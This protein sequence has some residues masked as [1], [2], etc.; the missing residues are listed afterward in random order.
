MNNNSIEETRHLDDLKHVLKIMRTTI[1]LLFFSIMFI[2]ASNS[3]SQGLI[4]RLEAASIKEV[5]KK[6]RRTVISSSCS[7]TQVKS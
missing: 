3:F 5:C 2:S 6:S 7:L 1:C 4:D